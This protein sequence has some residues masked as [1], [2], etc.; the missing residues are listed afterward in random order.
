MPRRRVPCPAELLAYL[1][2]R[3][4]AHQILHFQK[5]PPLLRW[6]VIC[7]VVNMH[8]RC[9]VPVQLYRRDLV[10]RQV[11]SKTLRQDLSEIR[12]YLQGRR[13]PTESDDRRTRSPS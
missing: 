8:L 12:I 5:H 7:V 10:V 6:E 9:V 2:L 13:V 1:H 4:A 3:P 11:M